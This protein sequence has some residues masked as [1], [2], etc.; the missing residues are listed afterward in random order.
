MHTVNLYF[1]TSLFAKDERK[2]NDQSEYIFLN[3]YGLVKFKIFLDFCDVNISLISKTHPQSYTLRLQI[4]IYLLGWNF[5]CK[6]CTVF[7][8]L[9]KL[10]VSQKTKN[11]KT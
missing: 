2:I 9:K 1:E 6:K 3:L 11:S 8:K 7:R 4:Q 10:F 5:A